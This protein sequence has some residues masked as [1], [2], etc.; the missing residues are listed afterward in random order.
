MRC[1]AVRGAVVFI[2]SHGA[3]WP[4]LCVNHGRFFY[5]NGVQVYIFRF[6]VWIVLGHLAHFVQLEI[7]SEFGLCGV[8]HVFFQPA[9][10]GTVIFVESHGAC[11]QQSSLNADVFR[12][13]HATTI[14]IATSR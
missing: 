1:A 6:Y 14:L 13:Q 5:V 4:Q 3:L 9:S 8:I 12:M 11:W 7:L 10:R 2:D